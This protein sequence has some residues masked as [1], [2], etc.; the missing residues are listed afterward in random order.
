MRDCL[1]Y[2]ASIFQLGLVWIIKKNVKIKQMEYSVR[3][4]L[5]ITKWNN[6]SF[7][8]CIILVGWI[9]FS[10]I[11]IKMPW[12][13]ASRQFF[14]FLFLFF[15]MQQMVACHLLCA[16]LMI[17]IMLPA[18]KQVNILNCANDYRGEFCIGLLEAVRKQPLYTHDCG[19]YTHMIE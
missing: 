10:K 6:C 12:L 3:P 2:E 17:N 9:W 15:D 19:R 18:S 14:H 7:R 13:L 11:C 16:Y 1:S 8:M 4:H 5:H